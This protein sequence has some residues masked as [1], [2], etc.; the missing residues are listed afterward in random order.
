MKTHTG[1]KQWQNALWLEIINAALEGRWHDFSQLHS[2]NGPAVSRYAATTTALL[3]WFKDFNEGKPYAEQV[4]P[5]NFLLALQPK[6]THKRCK[7]VAT[8]SVDRSDIAS[9]CFD[10]ATGDAVDED[11][12]KTY[13]E[14][15]SQYPI[16]PEAKF[17]NG[18]YLDAGV[19]QRRHVCAVSIQHIGKEANKWEEQAVLGVDGEA[20]VE[21]G[22]NAE[23]YEKKLARVRETIV[24]CGVK[25][26]AEASDLSQR[27]VLNIRKGL[28]RPSTRTLKILN[29]AILDN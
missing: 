6:F 13:L 20:Q 23:E 8:F 2:F 7:P 16:H 5:F 19:T 15:L 18:D 10:R 17:A 22:T 26:V 1:V 3:R 24:K 4:K 12:L 9:R 11:M 28:K 29:R 27:H 25:K 21:Y 14:A